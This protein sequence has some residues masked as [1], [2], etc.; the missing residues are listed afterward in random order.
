[1][2]RL[3]Q[4]EI[5]N[6]LLPSVGFDLLRATRHKFVGFEPM[7]IKYTHGS[8]PGHAMIFECE[9]TGAR[10]RWGYQ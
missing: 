2:S 5:T 3:V 9:E 8:K 10:R 1:M 6:P 7:I 4:P